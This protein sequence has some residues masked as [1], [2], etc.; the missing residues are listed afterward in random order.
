MQSEIPTLTD[1]HRFFTPD[2]SRWVKSWF[3]FVTP[4]NCIVCLFSLLFFA[5]IFLSFFR[6]LAA[7]FGFRFSV[8][9]RPSAFGF[10]I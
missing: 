6:A 5:S 1:E 10:R 8:F 4:E 3:K 2:A 9:L 7:N